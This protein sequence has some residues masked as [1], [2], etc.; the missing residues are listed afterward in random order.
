MNPA[1]VVSY[2]DEYELSEIVQADLPVPYV[3]HLSVIIS[4]MCAELIRYFLF[5]NRTLSP[6]LDHNFA[7]TLLIVY[8]A[9]FVIKRL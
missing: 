3:E 9:L 6:K 1:I 8:P 4:A 7:Q 2:L 5:N